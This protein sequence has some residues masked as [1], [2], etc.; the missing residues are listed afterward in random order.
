MAVARAAGAPSVARD[1]PALSAYS[2]LVV[3]IGKEVDEVYR[4]NS[5][6]DDSEKISVSLED[7]LKRLRQTFA[8]KE[9]VVDPNIRKR[10]E[11]QIGPEADCKRLVDD[12]HNWAGRVDSG[13]RSSY[14][15]PRQVISVAAREKKQKAAQHYHVAKQREANMGCDKEE[16]END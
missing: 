15:P 9:I 7:P 8:R 4:K 1:Q 13:R 11:K 10:K 14:Q 5:P 16:T 6:H 3:D 12:G 2:R